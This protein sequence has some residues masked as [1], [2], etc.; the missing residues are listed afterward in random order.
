ML[1][2]CSCSV[3]AAPRTDHSSS[4]PQTPHCHSLHSRAKRPQARS[5]APAFL[6][7]IGDWRNV[8]LWEAARSYLLSLER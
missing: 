8:V 3:P 7:G 4:E 1:T 5:C 2:I 6:D